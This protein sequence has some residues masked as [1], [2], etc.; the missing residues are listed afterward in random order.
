MAAEEPRTDADSSE[1]TEE[2]TG[3]SLSIGSPDSSRRKFMVAGATTWASV[4]LA[5]CSGGGD[6]GDGDD[7]ED[8]DTGSADGSDDGSEPEPQPE[9]YVVTDDMI[10]GSADTNPTAET[11]GYVS[12]CAPTR[13]FTPGMRPVWY[14]GVH[15]PSTGDYVGTDTL[16]SVVISTDSDVVGDIELSYV[17]P[18]SED[19][20][21]ESA[22]EWHGSYDGG[23]PEDIET[24]TVTYTVDIAPEGS[25][26]PV[27]TISSEFE[28]IELEAS[29]A[30]YVV[31]DQTYAGGTM[32]GQTDK[33]T[34]GCL[35]QD[36][37]S[38]NY[39][40]HFDVGIWNGT[41][42]EMAGPDDINSAEIQFPNHDFGPVALSFA[43]ANDDD[44]SDNEW[45]RT[46]S[47]GNIS[48]D[49]AWNGALR[50]MPSGL[51][52]EG[53]ST[54]KLIY[55]VAIEPAN[56]NASV[57]PVGVYRNY[58]TVVPADSESSSS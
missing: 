49:H 53:E 58:I 6:G 47:E 5:G 20:D 18:D 16:D 46:D 44:E 19:A 57:E 36:V 21:E 35:E 41:T 42:G 43:P 40:V 50:N 32:G 10:A 51:V 29:A 2:E 37:F 13:R 8:D 45:D 15:D 30:N 39:T 9:N 24:G 12:S 26:N 31:T 25:Y 52:P 4:G 28:I 17:D 1:T 3:G 55:E 48:E 34:Q 11:A 27:S 54:T 56:E 7:G 22:G 38:S 14:V 33:Y 23:L